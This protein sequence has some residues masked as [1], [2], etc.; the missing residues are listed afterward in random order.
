MLHVFSYT[1]YTVLSSY[2][3]IL[4]LLTC[5]RV[6]WI[7]IDCNSFHTELH[8]SLSLYCFMSRVRTSSTQTK[9]LVEFNALFVCQ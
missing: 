6:V 7:R 2:W 9:F 1:G 3:G 8:E 5:V 4:Q